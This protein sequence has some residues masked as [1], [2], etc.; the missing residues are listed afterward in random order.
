[1]LEVAK[2]LLEELVR[3]IFGM[4]DVVPSCA[5]GGNHLMENAHSYSNEE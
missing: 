3:L 2:S 1:M 4:N 5:N